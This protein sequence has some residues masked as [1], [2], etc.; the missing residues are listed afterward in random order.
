MPRFLAHVMPDGMLRPV[1]KERTHRYVGRDVWL[2]LHETAAV[3]IRSDSARGYQWAVVYAEI[4][5]QTGNDPDSIH[6]GLKREA[7]RV[8]ILPAEFIVVGSTLLDAEP[9][10]KQESDLFWRY[11]GWIR[12]GA[13]NGS[14]FGQGCRFHIPEPNE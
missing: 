14:L 3:G 2:E 12:E 1:D 9:T 4:A 5:H 6:Y 8:G 13:E 11:I 7:V 10:T